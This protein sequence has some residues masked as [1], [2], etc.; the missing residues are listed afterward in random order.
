MEI[1][2]PLDNIISSGAYMGIESG[3]N[4]NPGLGLACEAHSS[5]VRKIVDY[6]KNLNF[7]RSD[8]SINYDTVVFYTT[9]LLMAEGWD[10]K[11]R[12]IAGFNI[13]PSEYFCPLD[14]ESGVLKTTDNTYSIHHYSATWI[15]P[16]QM[17]YRNMKKI[18]GS[19]FASLCSLLFKKL[20]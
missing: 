18:F 10:G 7:Y 19:R 5:F 8:G 4:V 20:K 1:I 12:S 17:L 9:K 6:Y 13:Y 2:R 11:Q 14:Y 16:K 15:T 3:H